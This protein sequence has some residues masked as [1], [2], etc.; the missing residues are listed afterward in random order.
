MRRI[1]ILFPLIFLITKLVGLEPIIQ[2][3]I[4]SGVDD[5]VISDDGKYF[6]CEAGYPVNAVSM[7]DLRQGKQ[8]RNFD[9][10]QDII[11][12]FKYFENSKRIVITD[13]KGSLR[14]YDVEKDVLLKEEKLAYGLRLNTIFFN[15]EC[16]FAITSDGKNYDLWDINTLSVI[17]AKK[18]NLEYE[19]AHNTTH[20][21]GTDLTL[22]TRQGFITVKNWKT[23][24]V[25]KELFLNHRWIRALIP[26]KDNKYLII[27]FDNDFELYD[28]KNFNLLKTYKIK[29]KL[30]R[31]KYI[32]ADNS[33]IIA[34]DNSNNFI[35]F[36]L[37]TQ[38]VLNT[39]KVSSEVNCV[40]ADHRSGNLIVGLTDREIL[41]FDLESLKLLKTI[42]SVKTQYFD[43]EFIMIDKG[44]YLITAA[45]KFVTVWDMKKLGIL[46]SAEFNENCRCLAISEDGKKVAT[47]HEK[48]KVYVWS[49]PD[50]KLLT[51]IRHNEFDYVNSLTFSKD[52]E[53]LFIGTTDKLY[54][55]DLKNN[56]IMNNWW[57]YAATFR[58][59]SRLFLA[60]DGKKLCYSVNENDHIVV[61]NT[62][63]KKLDMISAIDCNDISSDMK[64]FTVSDKKLGTVVLKDASGYWKNLKSEPKVIK[65]LKLHNDE[66]YTVKL[67]NNKKLI[68]SYGID[69]GVK[70]FKITD[71][72]L[73]K[74]LFS[75]EI[76]D[77]NLYSMKFSE[78]DKKLYTRI[79][80]ELQIWKASTGDKIVT[81]YQTD[82]ND[83]LILTPD[84][85]YS[86]SKSLVN[87]FHFTGGLQYFAY[88]NFDLIYNRPDIIYQRLFP[89]DIQQIAIL[90][91]SYRNRLEKLG[92]M[93]KD[94]SAEANVPEINIM[95]KNIPF[96]SE[97]KDLKFR[98]SAKDNKYKL[99]SINIFVNN[100]P[101]HD[102]EVYDLRSENTSEYNKEIE[103]E[104]SKGKNLI[105]ISCTNEKGISSIVK[106]IDITYTGKVEKPDLYVLSIGVSK[107]TTPEYNLNYASK[108]AGDIA[109][110]FNTDFKQFNKIYTKA[111]LDT[112]GTKENIIDSSDFLKDSKVDDTVIVFFAGHGLLDDDLNYYYAT[113]DTDF[114]SPSGKAL[115]YGE[116]DKLLE[117]ARSRNKI[118]MIDTCHSGEIDKPDAELVVNNSVAEGSIKTRAIKIKKI[119]RKESIGLDNSYDLMR[120]MFSDLRRSNGAIVISASGGAE[121]ALESDKWK[122]GVF[123]FSVI[124]GLKNTKA[125]LNYDGVIAASELSE[126]VTENVTK[127]TNNKQKPTVR[128]ENI[129][130][131]FQIYESE[132]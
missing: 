22:I 118:L 100:V 21:S 36:D 25:V 75:N 90:S 59:V 63:Q 84:N 113:C 2:N 98:I 52:G 55:W 23:N 108:D 24:R 91:K 117:S 119:K 86:V 31:P 106:D 1:L 49:M 78:D 116:I 45:Y 44:R 107:F 132:W 123:T 67:S 77:F 41:Y 74:E 17:G 53:Q 129:D 65:T 122:N 92:I 46:K 80:K 96:Y 51:E 34:K 15:T 127:L 69:N 30:I 12:G 82:P 93:E 26:S 58:S 85:Y 64:M 120:E 71:I 68:A 111:I 87:L 76:K 94:L 81:L 47:G 62:N 88:E 121:Y 43:D 40:V 131:D 3:S 19:K 128:Q 4:S 6:F 95:K 48:N 83:Y 50:L 13:R 5:I 28:M 11:T 37:Q 27:G 56:M 29:D 110:L 20:I 130:N 115:P 57:A 9:G 60:P 112:D 97:E 104:L 102:S 42:S 8:L 70:N 54:R 72:T 99:K 14:I 114:L 38:K 39:V 33:K 124:D 125:D 61:N 32:S 7:W 66:L 126:F 105:K 101:I 73:G 109:D 16:D 10:F 35:V 18:I 79:G 103:I 89:E